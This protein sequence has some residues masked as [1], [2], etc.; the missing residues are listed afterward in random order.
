MP[1]PKH[2]EEAASSARNLK[3]TIP[4]SAKIPARIA[5]QF[6]VSS[7]KKDIGLFAKLTP[8]ASSAWAS[9]VTLDQVDIADDSAPQVKR[10]RQR[11]IPLSGT[12]IYMRSPYYDLVTTSA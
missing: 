1:S 7:K 6:Q 8:L 5:R 11:N 10:T 12:E 2:V 9:I 4:M 3:P